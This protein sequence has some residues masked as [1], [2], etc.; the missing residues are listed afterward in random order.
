MFKNYFKIAVRNIQRHKVYAAINIFGLAFGL[1]AFW[2]ILLYIAD[3]LSYD[4]Y[5][6]N[7]GRICRVVQ[8]A[9]WAENDLHTAP[10]SAPFAAAFK[11]EFAEVQEATRI[12]PEG[13]SNITY[14][15]N[16]LKVDDIFFTDKNIFQVFT[17]PFLYG[18]PATALAT[19]QAIVI[20][21]SLAVKFFG[22]AQK[23]LN[24]TIYFENNFPN[25]IT[26]VIKDIPQNSHLQ[27]SALRSLPADYS[28]GWQ[29]FNVYTYLLLQQGTGFKSLEAKLPQF[30]AKTIKKAMKI[31]D[32]KMELQPLT[33]IHLYSDLQYEIGP[34][35]SISRVY[36]FIAIALLIL[37]IAI[38]N[39]I[40]LS[41]ARS[42]SRV[43]EV[44]IRQVVGSGRRQ[45]GAMFLT[46]S[47]LVTF[48]AACI[49][50]LIMQAGLPLFNQLTE[51]HLSVWRFGQVKTLLFLLTFS[52]FTGIISG[53]YPSMVLS[54]FKTIPALK[55][56][57]D[58]LF[59]NILFRKS[60][61]VFQFVITVVMIAGSFTIYRQLQYATHK[62][63]GFNKDQVLTF[64]ID[65][66]EVRNHTD[67]LKTQL[68]LNPSIQAVAVAGNPIGNNNLGGMGYFFETQNGDFSTSTTVAQ[69]LMV[70]ADYAPTMEIKILAGRNFSNAVQSDKYGAALINETLLK[71]L[72]WNNPIG[73]KMRFRIDEE[74][75]L[76]ER[77][78]I[79]VVKDLHTYSLQHKIE[80]LVMVMPPAP[81]MGDN[82]Y[83]KIAKG[84][85][86][87]ALAYM[88]KVYHRFD[89]R[90]PL[91]YHFLDANFVKQ[92]AG[93]KKQGQLALAFTILAVVISC[94]GLFGLA[95]F[96]T[97][98]RTK[99]IGIRKV[100]GASV[101]GIL[102][103]LSAECL[104]LV[105]VA[106][107]ISLPI[108]W[109]ASHT[110]LQDFAYRINVEWWMFLLAGSIALLIAL[111]TVSSQ[112]LKAA[113]ANPVKS[114]RT[115]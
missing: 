36:M 27:F 88:N 55:G 93:E 65:D 68:L 77:T 19:P 24:Q 23:A 48:I 22:E 82:L 108:G 105:L 92:Y 8:H 7:A 90:N 11:S 56:Q 15:G 67:A 12:I 100:L 71:K 34:N 29:N 101:P 112:G 74:G 44:G 73:K 113:V 59:A 28:G 95:T 60:L 13:G 57:M 40:N 20:N 3:E 54:R 115:E 87:E 61:V 89:K 33:S 5:N 35:S 37:I 69:E 91:E 107:C 26:G 104:Q 103:M 6:A 75:T 52:L 39:Y 58:N 72:D 10:T 41:T 45:L 14:N 86:N 1:A 110:W 32:Y 111:I 31:D 79:G 53:I 84:N 9:R 76:G 51:K 49:G 102:K 17:F 81:S 94:L 80:P 99:E 18:D 21:E 16:M 109:W 85:T 63:L 62:D 96:S 98:Q 46:E 114:L 78:V 25:K 97:A 50:V 4:S 2:M 47:V 70:D 83:V 43:R 64:H 42:A 106:A 66:D 30:A 38:I